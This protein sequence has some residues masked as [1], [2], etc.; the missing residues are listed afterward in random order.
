M[1]VFDL[2]KFIWAGFSFNI[3]IGDVRLSLFKKLINLTVLYCHKLKKKSLDK[4]NLL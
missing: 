1:G 2:I 4:N 3:I